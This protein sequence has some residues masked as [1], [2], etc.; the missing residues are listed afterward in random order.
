MAYDYSQSFLANN[1]SIMNNDNPK[2]FYGDGNPFDGSTLD[3]MAMQASIYGADQA[4][5]SAKEANETNIMLAR[6]ATAF[7]REQAQ[8]QMDFQE[9][10]A[11]TA[12]Q[13]EMRD[14]IAAGLNPI[15]TATGGNGAATPAGAS[16]NAVSARVDPTVKSNPYERLVSDTLSAKRF[17]EIEKKNQALSEKQFDVTLKQLDIAEKKLQFEGILLNDTLKNSSS[18]RALNSSMANRNDFLNALSSEQMK[19]YAAQNL[20]YPILADATTAIGSGWNSIKNWLSSAKEFSFA[21]EISNGFNSVL[22]KL[23]LAPEWPKDYGTFGDM[24]KFNGLDR[25]TLRSVYKRLGSKYKNEN[26]NY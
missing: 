16:A 24:S 11:N 20:L 25:D 4:R 3:Q 1:P 18:A 17:R 13:R 21:D 6:E 12:H 15:L 10:M 26:D 9:R 19:S 5:A 8:K 22:V 2:S 23:G 7:N 14:L